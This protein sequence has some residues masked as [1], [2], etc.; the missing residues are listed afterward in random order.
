MCDRIL[1]HD[2]TNWDNRQKRHAAQHEDAAF[3]L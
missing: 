1:I 3:Q 2:A